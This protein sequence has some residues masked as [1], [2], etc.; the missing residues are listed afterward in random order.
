MKE[1]ARLEQIL[2]RFKLTS[3]VSYSIRRKILRLKR[4]TLSKI[5]KIEK[6]DSMFVSAAVNFHYLLNR[7]GFNTTL[8][9]GARAFAAAAVFSLFVIISSSL[10]VVYNYGRVTQFI[11]ALTGI[12]VQDYQKGFVLLAKGDAKII[13]DNKELPAVKATD[14]LITKDE[15]VTGADGTIMFQMEIKT[16]VRMMP[17]SMGAVGI[18]LKAKSIFLRQGTV[19]CNVQELTKNEKFSVTTPN[20]MVNVAGTQFSITYESEK[21][22]VTVIKGAVQ[23]VNLKNNETTQVDEGKTAVITG[24]GIEV[25][26]SEEA[27][28]IILQRFGRL[29]YM[30]NMKDKSEKEMDMFLEAVMAL[31]RESEKEKEED[32][33][34]VTLEDIKRKYGKLEEIQLYNGKRY[35][36]AIISRGGI[37]SFV[38][39]DGIKKIPAKDVKNVRIIK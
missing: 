12:G 4:K 39:L 16:L 3:P 19:L 22:I 9:G 11:I 23:A 27:E 2:D 34:I 25:K 8:A 29:E 18:D 1:S 10:A 38:T 20:A 31:D 17:K 28:K 33:K 35:T 13:R 24:D 21:T 26:Y 5:L 14:R 15:V 36:G 6:Y 37:Y 30:N 7:L 32:I